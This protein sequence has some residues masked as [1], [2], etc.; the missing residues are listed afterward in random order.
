MICTWFLVCTLQSPA[1]PYLLIDHKGE[2]PSAHSVYI[3]NHGQ[4]TDLYGDPAPKMKYYSLQTAPQLFLE[5]ASTISF[6][7]GARDT[8]LATP[9]TLYKIMMTFIGPNANQESLPQAYEYQDERFNFILGHCPQGIM[10]LQ[11]AR[12]I[13]YHDVYPYID[14]HLYSNTWGPKLYIV[15]HPGSDPGDLLL[16]FAGQDSLTLDAFG[17]LRAHLKGRQLILPRG[18]CYQ[19]IGGSTQLVNAALEFG[20][21]PGNIYVSFE[22]VSY[23]PDH[24]LIIDISPDPFPMGAGGLPPEWST[25][26]GH[27]ET[28]YPTD[29]VVLN[30]GGLLVCG[31]TTSPGFPLFNEQIGEF[32]GSRMAYYSEFDHQYKRVYTTFFGGNQFDAAESIALSA[33]E[34][35]VFLF[36]RTN[37]TNLPVQPYGSGFFDSSPRTQGDNCYIARFSRNELTLGEPEWVSYFGQGIWTCNCLRVDAQDN[38]HILGTTSGFAPQPFPESTCQGTDTTFPIC[39][40]PGTTDYTQGFVAGGTDAFYAR[41]N[42]G[43]Q[44]VH[45]TFFGGA[46]SDHG[47]ELLIDPANGRVYFV[48]ATTS[49]RVGTPGCAPPGNGSFPL[50]NSLGGY[51]QNNIN[52]NNSP[53]LADGYIACMSPDGALLWSTYVGSSADD[54]GHAIGRNLNGDLYVAGLTSAMGYS[55]TVCAPPAGSGLPN[56]ASG[57]QV[58]FPRSSEQYDS[59]II[60]FNGQ[61]L[62]LAWSTFVEASVLSFRPD[63]GA[64]MLVAMTTAAGSN[65]TA[66]LPVMPKP[67]TYFQPMHADQFAPGL[68]AMVM[69]FNTV[70][71]LAVSTYFGGMGNDL[72]VRALPW[73][74]GRLY[75]VG[76]SRSLAEFPFHC[77]PTPEPYCYLTYVTQSPE[78]GEAFYAQL[79]YDVTIGVEENNLV[80]DNGQHVLVFPNPSSGS[81]FIRLAPEWYVSGQPLVTVYDITGRILNV[82]IGQVGA[83]TGTFVLEMSGASPGVRFIRMRSADGLL[84]ITRPLVIE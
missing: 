33:D 15:M 35:S 40:P 6:A 73:V 37:S 70:D 4:L 26:Y 62:A 12:R 34:S 54:T 11:G 80:D 74:G 43:A 50:C 68:D 10:G 56:C 48:G 75:L 38:V 46:G 3:P 67:N 51:F 52:V 20:Y 47:R 27:T 65:G 36:G 32:E 21:T 13:V 17:K 49:P 66:P 71:E 29:G 55:S 61:T 79:Q 58:Q 30:S 5:D 22:P 76:S 14:F 1:Q 45:S 9:D 16:A 53:A 63:E 23:D 83:S 7:L 19:Q 64:T 25:F 84:D 42:A 44:L 78:T 82:R 59:Y 39:D 60:K 69:G 24:M 41:F 72:A 18:V 77:P 2:A 28:D 8:V 57:S 81:V 31:Y